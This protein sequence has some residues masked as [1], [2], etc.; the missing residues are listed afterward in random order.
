MFPHDVVV[1]NRDGSKAD[2]LVAKG[3]RYKSS[4]AGAISESPI[5]IVC[6]GN[7][8]NADSFLRTPESLAAL[9][10]RVLVQLTTG[11]PKSASSTQAWAKEAG[12]SYLDGAI[13]SYPSEIGTAASQFLVAGDEPAYAKAEP[14]LC[15]L[16]PQLEYLGTDPARPAALDSAI[17]STSL[18]LMFGI[19]NG[20]ALCEATGIPISQF[21]DLI[22]PDFG[23]EGVAFSENAI[24]YENNDLDEPEAFLRTW[25]EGL[26]P[27]AE[28]MED[29]GYDPVFPKLLRRMMNRA[30]DSGLGEK[31]VGAL[32]KTLRPNEI[33]RD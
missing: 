23:T 25:A 9:K 13:M 12:V 5:T 19:L 22:K 20:A 24:K 2:P 7:Y 30:I 27:M 16:A 4:P 28:M 3:A 17:L 6:V 31:D 11:S 32:I 10:G 21:T 14:F 29:A 15:I 1:W 33:R 18:G 26:D 8:D